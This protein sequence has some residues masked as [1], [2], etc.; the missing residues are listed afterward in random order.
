MCT[1]QNLFNVGQQNRVL[2]DKKR[3]GMIN[4]E[5]SDHQRP[6]DVVVKIYQTTYAFTNEQNIYRLV[7]YKRHRHD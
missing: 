2:T 6:N 7:N 1:E 3:K 5:T 4:N